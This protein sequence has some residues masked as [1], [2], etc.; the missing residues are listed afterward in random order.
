[1]GQNIKCPHCGG[2]HYVSDSPGGN[3][4]AHKVDGHTGGVIRRVQEVAA[5]CEKSGK[6]YHVKKVKD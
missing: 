4:D 5:Y 1:M 3:V 2:T 6:K